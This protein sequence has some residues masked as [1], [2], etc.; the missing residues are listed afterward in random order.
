MKG[1]YI[2]EVGH[3][4]GLIK[5]KVY[6]IIDENI[7]QYKVENELGGFSWCQKGKFEIQD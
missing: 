5:N 7:E 1:K 4:D 2:S 3:F 6:E